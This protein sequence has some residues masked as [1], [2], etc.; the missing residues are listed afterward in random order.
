MKTLPV[1][2]NVFKNVVLLMNVRRIISESSRPVTF[3][4]PRPRIMLRSRDTIKIIRTANKISFKKWLFYI[5]KFNITKVPV[6][7][8]S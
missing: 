5:F 8:S 4:S 6:K 2:G 3:R 7:S 1:I